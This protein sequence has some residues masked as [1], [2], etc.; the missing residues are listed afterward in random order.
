MTGLCVGALVMWCVFQFGVVSA[1][2]EQAPCRCRIGTEAEGILGKYVLDCQ[3]L[4]LTRIPTFEPQEKPFH[5]I[6]LGNNRIA[7]LG[8][9]P[10]FG[11][12]T[13]GID[14]GFNEIG[15]ISALAFCGLEGTL[16]Y[17][18]LQNNRFISPPFPWL[19]TLTNLTT[20]ILAG[21]DSPGKIEF[22]FKFR[23]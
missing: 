15:N 19:K 12:Q 10:F 9:C 4:G 22:E 8:I 16:R 7:S 21:N 23:F 13:E 11:L 3:N 5:R 2:P 18:N 20:L 6:L 17:L 1:C 14:L